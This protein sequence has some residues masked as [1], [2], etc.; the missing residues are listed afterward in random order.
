MTLIILRL[1]S[2]NK[3]SPMSEGV[4]EIWINS[5]SCKSINLTTRD[6]QARMTPRVATVHDAVKESGRVLP[7]PSAFFHVYAL[8]DTPWV[9]QHYPV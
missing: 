3:P 8:A 2:A 9:A 7:H 5:Q 1:D 6:M 4:T